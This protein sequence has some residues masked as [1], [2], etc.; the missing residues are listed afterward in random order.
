MPSLNDAL[1]F[2]F[3]KA[4]A[5][6]DTLEA[7]EALRSIMIEHGLGVALLVAWQHGLRVGHIPRSFNPNHDPSIPE[8]RAIR[9]DRECPYMF[10]HVPVRQYRRRTDKLV[11][12]NLLNP[13][14][15]P[16]LFVYHEDGLIGT[17]SFL[18]PGSANLT[19]E[20]VA[21]IL[22]AL[23]QQGVLVPANVENRQ[24]QFKDLDVKR[25]IEAS[26]EQVYVRVDHHSLSRSKI[27]LPTG[28]ER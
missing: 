7:N 8:A 15:D 20:G 26:R 4:L 27:R 2:Q 25:R 28:Y 9:P 14:A 1:E 5:T 18:N 22:R 24:I 10:M 11:E 16:A 3:S 17:F 21:E 6:R 12:H 23:A 19:E 13:N